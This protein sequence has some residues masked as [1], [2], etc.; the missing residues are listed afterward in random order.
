MKT[1]LRTHEF[2]QSPQTELHY[3]LLTTIA[4]SLRSLS[5]L[6]TTINPLKTRTEINQ[7]KLLFRAHATSRAGPQRV[8]SRRA[9]LVAQAYL[10]F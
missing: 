5:K 6:Q 4:L 8:A 9:H 2:R 1:E 3:K 7:K 10:A